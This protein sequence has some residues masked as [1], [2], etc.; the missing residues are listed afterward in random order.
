MS[1]ARCYGLFLIVVI[2]LLTLTGCGTQTASEEKGGTLPEVSKKTP[3]V[4][5][6]SYTIEQIEDLSFPNVYRYSVRVVV[7]PETKK[8]EL[9][10]I[11]REIAKDMRETKRY[12]ALSVYFYDYPELIGDIAPLG[13]WIDAPYG[14]WAR[15][16]GAKYM[17]YSTHQENATLLKE[18]DWSKRPT[19]EQ[20]DVYIM[21]QQ[22]MSA[23][24]KQTDPNDLTARPDE[25]KV[26]KAI[27]EKLNKTV[28]DINSD[29]LEV[30]TWL[31]NW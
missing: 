13:Q 29:L 8:D 11:A 19:Q 23:L 9:A 7:E 15:A 1:R 18:K 30:N 5:L 14:D 21:F 3:T 6:P 20:V 22:R 2:L 10:A 16:G 4:K 12:F 31:C 17:D 26:I 25:D 28:E 24:W 27:A